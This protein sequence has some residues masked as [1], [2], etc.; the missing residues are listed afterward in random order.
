M[1]IRPPAYLRANNTICSWCKRIGHEHD[2]CR[3]RLNLCYLCGGKDHYFRECPRNRYRR[4]MSMQPQNQLSYRDFNRESRYNRKPDFRTTV[5]KGHEDQK[6]NT[7]NRHRT[8]SNPRT[9]LN[10]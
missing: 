1:N 8:N 2:N 4:S 3:F 5:N 7:F 10:W 6:I 9:N